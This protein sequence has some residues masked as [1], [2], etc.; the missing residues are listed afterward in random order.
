MRLLRLAFVA[1][2]AATLTACGGTSTTPT[3]T[4]S[5]QVMLKDS[6]F[7]DA[8]AV[9]VTFTQ[10]SAHLS[11]ADFQTLAFADDASSR[12]CDLKKLTDAQD[13]LGVGPLPS[14]HYTE[15]RLQVSS[16]RLYFD[17][18]S[19]GAA[20][21][22][23][24]EAPGGASAVVT[25]PSGDVRLNREFDVMAGGSTSILLDFD[26][27]RSILQTGAGGYMMTPVISIVS[28]Q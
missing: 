4:G 26:G 5:L 27:D 3:N 17:N 2:M 12:T 11:G 25:I 7:D 15:L 20:C 23:A 13:V 18:P 10:V 21:A 22:P 16:A 28:V 19:A 14:G 24:M 6:P 9:L 8:R 1:G